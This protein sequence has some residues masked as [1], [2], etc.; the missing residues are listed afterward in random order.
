MYIPYIVI[1]GSSISPKHLK[2]VYVND[3]ISNTMNK[4]AI[5]GD[6]HVPIGAP[7]VCLSEKYVLQLQSALTSNLVIIS[8]SSMGWVCMI[9]TKCFLFFTIDAALM[10]FKCVRRHQYVQGF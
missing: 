5:T 8:F 3:T 9:S 4:L 2:V 10:V 6:V 7:S 1:F